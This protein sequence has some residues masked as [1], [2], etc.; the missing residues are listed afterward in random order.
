[1][2]AVI[3]KIGYINCVLIAFFLIL[4]ISVFLIGG[5]VGAYSW[6]LLKL[7]LPFI[8]ALGL[9]M[10][11][12]I[13]II[14]LFKKIKSLKLAFNVMVNILMIFPILMTMNIIPL[15]YPNTVEHA[16]PSV[17][18]NFPLKE[19]TVVGWGGN[20]VKDNLPHAI[21]S[22]ER[23]AYDLL[24]EPYNINSDNNE[25]YGIWNKI[26]YSPVSGVVIATYDG[27]DD[28][29]P[30]SEDFNS[31]EGNYVYIEIEE[32]G[33]YLL[34]NHLKKD[35]VLVKVGD[36]VKPGDLL[37]R[38]GNSGSTSE[39][40]LHIHHQRQNPTKTIHP[41]IAEGLP[42]FFRDLNVSSMPRKGDVITPQN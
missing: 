23:W 21:W 16:Q 22:S 33:T 10:N 20:N 27:E 36:K 14:L 24:M 28:I 7:V 1:M 34:L 3:R 17:T 39:P 40:H 35:S 25:D 13:F 38:V 9:L 26:V 5:I 4:W 29:T 18:V 37:G 19:Q 11:L 31:L 12:I 8:G 42:L 41:V 32:T 30:G 6:T 15:A 2:K